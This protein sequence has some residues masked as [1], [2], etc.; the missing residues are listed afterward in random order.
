MKAPPKD[1]IIGLE[2]PRNGGCIMNRKL[3]LGC[4][5]A[6]ICELLFGLSFIFTKMATDQASELALISWR[7][8]IAFCPMGIFHIFQKKHFHFRGKD[9]RALVPIALLNPILYFISETVG[10]HLTTASE[11][12]A[13]LACIPVVALIFSSLILKEWP[14]RWQVTGVITTLSGIIIA[15]ISAGG[16][17]QFS[18]PGYLILSLA[19]IAYALYCVYVEKANDFTSLEITYVMLASGAATFGLFALTSSTLSGDWFSLIQLPFHKPVFA[20]AVLYQGLGCSLIGYLL[21]NYALATI[22]VN[23]TASFIG[24][25]TIISVLAGVVLLGEAFSP[26]QILAAILVIAGIYIANKN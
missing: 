11:S 4:L 25:S 21:S 1:D 2:I 8:I 23:R 17:S 6:A 5:A 14:S 26:L 13:F 22:G 16:S 18:L 12:G 15:V 3:I 20:M 7:F 24:L 9:I 19:V 10:I